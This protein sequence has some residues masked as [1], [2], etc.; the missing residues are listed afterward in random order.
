MLTYVKCNY[1][2]LVISNNYCMSDT[3]KLWKWNEILIPQE[4]LT[5]LVTAAT[6]KRVLETLAKNQSQIIFTNRMAVLVAILLLWWMSG[7]AT[8]IIAKTTGPS[9]E[10][11]ASVKQLTNAILEMNGN[12]WVIASEVQW[13]RWE[14]QAMQWNTHAMQQTLEGVL[15]NMNTMNQ[16]MAAMTTNTWY[17]VNSMQVMWTNVGRMQQWV[18]NMWSPMGWVDNFMRW[19]N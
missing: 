16:N 5:A 10:I 19:G 18:Q 7:L 14:V 3:S 15:Q 9:Q 12:V 6:N 4:A 1:Y 13:M 11:T 8:Y 2:I 17:M